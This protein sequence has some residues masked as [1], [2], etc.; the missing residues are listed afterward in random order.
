MAFFDKAANAVENVGKNVSKAA[1]DNVEIMRYSS[2]IEACESR[3]NELYR[4][5]GKRYYYAEEEITREAFIDLFEEIQSKQ[6]EINAL[7]NKIQILKGVEYCKKCGAELKKGTRFCQMC[8]TAVEVPVPKHLCKNC[9]AQLSGQEKFCAV[10][11]SRVEQNLN[12]QT[13]MD[14]EV[15]EQPPVCTGCG[16]R[17][18]GTESFCKYCGTP[19]A[20]RMLEVVDTECDMVTDTEE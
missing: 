11:G 8:G 12:D 1:K 9:G 4:E 15:T 5:L 13:V 6:N 16:E 10:C 14:A 17:L 7:K 20:P 3:M 19:V 18:M 2:A